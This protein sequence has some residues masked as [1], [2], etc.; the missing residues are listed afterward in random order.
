MPKGIE[1]RGIEKLPD[2][3]S[4]KDPVAELHAE[5]LSPQTRAV[6]PGESRTFKFAFAPVCVSRASSATVSDKVEL[7]EPPDRIVI[8]GKSSPEISTTLMRAIS[9][10]LACDNVFLRFLRRDMGYGSLCSV[11]RVRSY[12]TRIGCD[13]N[14]ISRIGL[15]STARARSSNL[16]LA[17]S[18]GAIASSATLDGDTSSRSS[19]MV[20]SSMIT[21]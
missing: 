3:L 5:L 13:C 8:P 2:A 10:I 19:G 15:T 14:F 18:S 9:G 20:F 7:L 16:E 12:F 17:A 11:N 4:F 6:T 21:S 1:F